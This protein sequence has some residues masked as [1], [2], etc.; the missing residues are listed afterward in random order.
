MSQISHYKGPSSGG[1]ASK[2]VFLATPSYTGK[3]DANYVY[4]LLQS[5]DELRASGI[6][7]EHFVLSYHCHVDDSRNSIVRDFLLS[8]CQEL[9]FLDADVSWKPSELV[10]LI[11]HDRD[12]VAGV[13]PKRTRFDEEY[14]VY[15]KPGT[16][17]IA[18]SDGLVE[19][20]GAPT[21]F[22]KIKRHVI[23][24]MAEAN[25]NR[26]YLGRGTRA[27]KEPYTIIFERILEGLHRWGG[28]YNFCRKWIEMGGK[29]FVDPEMILFHTGEEVFG[30]T[31]GDYWRKKHGLIHL[32]RS[33]A[34]Q[35][36]VQTLRDGT[37]TSETWHQLL[38]AWNNPYSADVE[39]LA[40][41]YE[42]ARSMKGPILETGCGLTSIVMALAN[43]NIEIHCLEHDP[44]WASALNYF[45]EEHGIKNIILHFDRLKEYPSGKWYSKFPDKSFAMALCDGPPRRISN[46]SLFYQLMGEQIKDAIVLMDD[47][48][49]D[50]ETKPIREWAEANG[51]QVRI[52]G[53]RRHFALSLPVKPAQE[54]GSHAS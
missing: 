54:I 1:P 53:R 16:E 45:T 13:Y 28:D 26:R 29:V 52:L 9:V 36:C 21:G 5:M 48:D 47:A 32:E 49:N 10:K 14:P 31:L 37:P 22:M 17:L 23:E 34:L 33:S 35:R 19:V 27:G 2:R 46:R 20:Y 3:L 25:K 4:T 41:C 50:D 38:T 30:G 7:I 11:G 40:T 8:N 6:E 42:L 18:D 12:V 39:L 51:R 44:V 15:V 24:K 43:P